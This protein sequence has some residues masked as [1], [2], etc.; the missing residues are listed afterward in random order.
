MTLLLNAAAVAEAIEIGSLI[1]S[2]E[3]GLN[4]QARGLAVVPPRMNLPTRGGSFR[5][6][7]AALNE[8]GLM[9]LKAFHGALNVGARYF[10]ALLEQ[11]RG[12]LLAIMDANY[13]TA[14]RTGAAT[15]I[16][17]RYASRAD[18]TTVGVIG[19]GVEA[20]TN[21]EAVCTVRPIER[22]TIFSPRSERRESF[23]ARAER[24]FSI[25]A[26]PVA[27][28]NAA[29]D[30][31]DIVI[32]ATNTARAAD[33]IAYRGAWAQPGT[34]INS[35]GSTLPNLREIDTACFARSDTVIV[36]TKEQIVEE[37]GDVIA[38]IEDG[39]FDVDV[40]MELHDV[41]AGLAI[42]RT[43]PSAV[44]L[45]KSVGTGL[46]DVM[47]AAAVYEA[48]LAKGIGLDIGELLEFK[49]L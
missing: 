49:E 28:P 18:S 5:V 47:A 19:S 29:V 38:A 8:S 30:G 48:A 45:Y 9:G 11:E 26:E 36:D 12:N 16:A 37:S 46:Q 15:A 39:V 31:V 3:R 17:T 14:A 40:A 22:A 23:A 32:V 44:T 27:T 41:A 35:I 13:L 43:D 21:L 10:I 34:H 4:E 25:L 7:P 42:C 2:I 1:E 24:E 6:M 33:P 20:W